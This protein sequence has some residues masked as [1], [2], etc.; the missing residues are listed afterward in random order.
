MEY[1]INIPDGKYCADCPLIRSCEDNMDEWHYHCILKE[2]D[3]EEYSE[4][5]RANN[6]VYWDKT[7]EVWDS[8]DP[9]FAKGS[10]CPAGGGN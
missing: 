9:R 1:S 8:K 10:W 6:Q 3:G 2:D 5:F 7:K 4:I